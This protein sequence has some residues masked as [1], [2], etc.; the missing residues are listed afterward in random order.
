MWV[1]G[2]V[3]MGRC[4]W[5]KRQRPRR[6]VGSS[7]LIYVYI[8]VYIHPHSPI[9]PPIHLR[10]LRR[11]R[12]G[13][14]RRRVKRGRGRV[15]W[16][17]GGLLWVRPLRLRLLVVP[18]CSCCVWRRR[19]RRVLLVLLVCAVVG[20]GRGVWGVVG[21]VGR[22]R[23]RRRVCVAACIVKGE[24][25]QS[26][27]M[28][29]DRWSPAGMPSLYTYKRGAGHAPGC[30]GGIEEA[31]PTITTAGPATS[32]PAAS[33]SRGARGR[34]RRRKGGRGRSCCCM[35]WG[36]GAAAGACC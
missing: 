31:A 8:Y 36:R 21:V 35:W 33:T 27:G 2:G 30:G 25:S 1:L 6:S 9:H 34:R 16:V 10:I 3:G 22:G 14:R 28:S 13:Q 5:V 20:E 15:L 12:E 18:S 23:G 24:R 4:A 11:R 19:G 26:V 29:I 7:P 32:E 17:G